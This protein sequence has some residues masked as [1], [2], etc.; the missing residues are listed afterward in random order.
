MFRFQVGEN[1]CDRLGLLILDQ[2]KYLS[3]VHLAELTNGIDGVAGGQ[4]L[5]QNIGGGLGA[6]GCFQCL[7]NE[8]HSPQRGGH[9]FTNESAELIHDFFLKL[10]IDHIHGGHFSSDIFDLRIAKLLHELG[11]QFRSDNNEK[12]SKSLRFRHRFVINRSHG[13]AFVFRYEPLTQGG[14]DIFGLLANERVEE[15]R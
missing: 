4:G 12:R 5:E 7:L 1:E 8:R 14:T 6:T 3:G 9:A 15:F 10:E 2:I 11:G 13:L